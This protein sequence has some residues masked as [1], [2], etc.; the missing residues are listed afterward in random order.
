MEHTR[1]QKSISEIIKDFVYSYFSIGNDLISLE[2]NVDE[3]IPIE[4]NVDDNE[5]ILEKPRLVRSR[6]TTSL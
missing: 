3:L 2:S 1:E 5:T 6:A 4:S